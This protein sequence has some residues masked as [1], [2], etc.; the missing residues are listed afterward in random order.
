[1]IPVQH[2][3]PMLVH[4]PIVLIFLLAA[5]DI[6]ATLGGRSISGRGVAGNFSTGIA[7]ATAAF[8]VLTFI[9]GGM[10]LDV[11]EAGGF[12]SDVAEIHE[13][14]GEMV[15]IAASIYALL[16]AGLWLKDVRIS[17]VASLIFPVAAVAGSVLV[18]VTAYYG[19][20]LV[21]ELGVNVTKI[22]L[23]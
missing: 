14:L 21:Y 23:N 17:G 2:I 9:F 16:R 5:F 13:G 18:A 22:A 7:I 1:M 3:H 8:A 6:V 10:A 20:Q 12:H 15:A 11:A 4:F 19:G